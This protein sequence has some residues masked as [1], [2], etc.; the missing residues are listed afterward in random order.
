MR[1]MVGFQEIRDGL[2]AEEQQVVDQ[3]PMTSLEAISL[4]IAMTC[5]GL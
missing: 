3:V 4:A 2:P 5:T 1:R